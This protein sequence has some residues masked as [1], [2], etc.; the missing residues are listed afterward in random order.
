MAWNI[1][2]FPAP[3]AAGANNGVFYGVF[4]PRD[5]ALPGITTTTELTDANRER[6]I[7]YALATQ[8]Y[9]QLNALPNKLGL[10]VARPTPTGVADNRINQSFSLTFQLM[11]NHVDNTV[12]IIP[13]P[14]NQ[15]GGVTLEQLFPGSA[16]V[17][18]DGA[19]PEPGIV[20]PFSVINAVGGGSLDSVVE[21]ARHWVNALYYSMVLYLEPNTAVVNASRGAA[22]GFVPPA[23]YIGAN[24]ITGLVE[25][26]LPLRSFFSITYSLMLQLQLNQ[27]AQTFDLAA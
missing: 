3:V 2:Y 9:E 22:V 8:L 27:T 21:D 10:A 12:G 1:A 17:Q 11:V 13:L 25:A 7:A 24:A 18:Q 6:K 5:T 26:D 14:G 20:I 4:V 15:I 19:I 16:V 23:N